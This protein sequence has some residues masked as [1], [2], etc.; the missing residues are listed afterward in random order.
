MKTPQLFITSLLLTPLHYSTTSASSTQAAQNQYQYHIMFPSN[1][2][3]T[4]SLGRNQQL[5][6]IKN[7]SQLKEANQATIEAIGVEWEV[8]KLENMISTHM[9]K[10][11]SQPQAPAKSEAIDGKDLKANKAQSKATLTIQ[12]KHYQIPLQP[13][14]QH[15]EDPKNTPLTPLSMCTLSHAQEAKAYLAP[16]DC[17]I[18]NN[19]KKIFALAIPHFQPTQNMQLKAGQINY[20]DTHQPNAIKEIHLAYI[21]SLLFFE[22]EEK[23][24]HVSISFS[25]TACKEIIPKDIAIEGIQ[26]DQIHSAAIM[27]FKKT[28]K[29]RN[30]LG[31]LGKKAP[32]HPITKRVF[33][34]TKNDKTIKEAKDLQSAITINEV[35]EAQ[36][37]KKANPLSANESRQPSVSW[38]DLTP[39]H[40]PTSSSLSEIQT[41]ITD[42]LTHRPTS[43][44]VINS[45]TATSTESQIPTS[46]STPKHQQAPPSLSHQKNS[47]RQPTPSSLSDIQMPITDE[48]THRPTSTLIMNKH[49]QISLESQM[50]TSPST[51]KHQQAPPSHTA[52]KHPAG[53]LK[54]SNTTKNKPQPSHNNFTLKISHTYTSPKSLKLNTKADLNWPL[55]I[56]PSLALAILISILIK[57][58]PPK[59]RS[60]RHIKPMPKKQ[61]T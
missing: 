53:N 37:L 26:A 10:I 9:G 22:M 50:P 58:T 52:P 6:K 2:I 13:K 32:T 57:A 18:K 12:E 4:T 28:K 44:P 14:N 41:P 38:I 20:T 23:K 47:L 30:L 19:E 24:D 42:E 46:P 7:L 29:K 36:P 54:K 25:S 49:T 60:K 31:R 39:G 55:W 16:F 21:A 8:A 1:E 33:Y 48:L 43:T 61:I 5:Y 45:H 15:K 34:H 59:K 27:Q 40:H 51:P 3:T 35:E 17:K 11:I 56:F